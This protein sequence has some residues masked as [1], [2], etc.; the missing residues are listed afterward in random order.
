MSPRSRFRIRIP[1]TGIELEWDINAKALRPQPTVVPFIGC[2]TGLAL[3]TGGQTAD[4]SVPI[5]YPAYAGPR[6]L[7]RLERTRHRGGQYTITSVENGLALDANLTEDLGRPLLMWS[8]H[9]GHQQRWHLRP[10]D[11]GVSFLV[12][13][14]RTGQRLEIPKDPENRKHPVLWEPH[15]DVNQRFLLFPPAKKPR[16]R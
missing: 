16:V 14:A 12:E 8:P 6:Q 13:S 15:D 3:D 9:G 11:D 1:F 2:H 5:L 7:W 4:G 10:T